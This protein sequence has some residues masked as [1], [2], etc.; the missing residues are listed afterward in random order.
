MNLIYLAVTATKEMP[1]EYISYV[2]TAISTVISGF[3]AYLIGRKK[4]SKSEFDELVIANKKFRDEIK[5]ELEQAKGTIEK[6][7]KSIDEK[8]KLIDVLQVEVSSLKQQLALRDT[9]IADLKME[10]IKKDY[11]ITLL[12]APKK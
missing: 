8:S 1:P 6:L 4:S 5:L 7:Q 10:M 3:F 12:K 9:K 2:V 11:E